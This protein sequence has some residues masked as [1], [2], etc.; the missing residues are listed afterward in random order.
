MHKLINAGQRPRLLPSH[1][2]LHL[3]NAVDQ[4]LLVPPPQT[5]KVSKNNNTNNNN[6]WSACVP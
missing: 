1:E 5:P 3:T 4:L 2:V 6:N